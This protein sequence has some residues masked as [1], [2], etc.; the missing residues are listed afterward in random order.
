MQDNSGN[1]LSQDKFTQ[2]LPP[3]KEEEGAFALPQIK[4]FKTKKLAKYKFNKKK[5]LKVSGIVAGVLLLIGLVLGFLIHRVYVRAINV[6]MA[7][8]N[9]VEAVREQDIEKVK[10]ETANSK[11]G[12]LHLKQSYSGISWMGALPLVGGYV[13]DGGHII[14]AGEYG[15]EA[16]EII[17]ATIEPYADI[18][19]FTGG[20]GQEENGEETAKDR[21]DFVVKTISEII[22]KADELITK[23]NLV[24]G[25]VDQI[26]PE[27]YPESFRGNPIRASLVGLI[28]T[29]DTFADAVESGKPLLESAPYMLGAEEER[30][31]LI[32]FQNDKELRPTGGFLTGY[33][34]ATVEKGKF[35]PVSSDDIYNLDARYRPTIDAPGPIIKHLKGPYLISNKLRLRDLNWNPDFYESMKVFSQEAGSAGLGEYDGIIAVDTEALVKILDVIGP[36]GVSGFGNF[37]TDIIP[38]CNCPQVV[39]ELESFA[40]IEGPVVWSENTGEIVFAPPNMDNRKRIIGPLMNAVLSNALGQT[41][42]KIPALFSAVFSSLM[43]KNVLF[44]ML[45]SKH[46][47]AVESFGVAGRILEYDA[48]YLHINDANLGGRKS[49]MYVTQEVHQEIEVAEDGSVEKTVTITYKNPERHDGWLN[50]VLPNWVRIYVPLGS[51]LIDFEGLEEREVPYEELGKTVFSGFFQ[52]RPLGVAVV[53]LKY[54]L[55]FTV[56]DE[57]RLFIQKQPGKNNILPYTINIGR[58]EDEFFLTKDKELK[59]KI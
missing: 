17:I 15:L 20:D 2:I 16:G 50:S 45:D 42:D 30:T 40:D 41:S 19:G 37:S 32:I 4:K 9:L 58:F 38:E 49:N 56:S 5:V 13:R 36:I 53:N 54:K 23:I 35:E 55:P 27:R 51:E 1:G 22:P 47:Q 52:L 26:V 24:R 46:Q 44:Y 21:L 29:V 48:D 18:I 7:A 6:K 8:E 28:E 3:A 25:E 31:Y 10:T 43:E 33:S 59:Y 39:Y 14:S 11:E 12:I 57:Y 34:I